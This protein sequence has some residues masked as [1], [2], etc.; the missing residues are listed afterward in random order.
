[1]FQVPYKVYEAK[2]V[3][4]KINESFKILLLN[5]KL[6]LKIKA[7]KYRMTDFASSSIENMA[8]SLL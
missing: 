1:M 2:F 6:F 5:L 8:S 3:L 7:L 4:I